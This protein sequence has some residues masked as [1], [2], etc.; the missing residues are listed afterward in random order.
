[1]LKKNRSNFI[2]YKDCCSNLLR[3]L[4]F[5]AHDKKAKIGKQGSSFKIYFLL[6]MA[7]VLRSYA[8]VS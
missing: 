1:M 4:I 6:E 8:R 3:M 5:F 7:K 2:Q